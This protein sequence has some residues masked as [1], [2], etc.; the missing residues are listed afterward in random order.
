MHILP[1][2]VAQSNMMGECLIIVPCE[3]R[4]RLKRRLTTNQVSKNGL[5]AHMIY[6]I[7]RLYVSAT[8]SHQQ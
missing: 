4:L 6:T 5:L 3:K 1:C 7:E 8:Q 2:G